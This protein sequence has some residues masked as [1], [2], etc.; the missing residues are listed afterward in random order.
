[1][2]HLNGDTEG[3]ARDL[4]AICVQSVHQHHK[5]NEQN[6]GQSSVGRTI[7]K[8]GPNGP[9]RV[10]EGKGEGEGREGGGE[11]EEGREEEREEREG[12]REERERGEGGEGG[13]RGEGRSTT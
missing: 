7:H 2:A 10:R 3:V 6:V 1:M 13:M 11:G 5:D 4:L 9:G 12:G 8:A